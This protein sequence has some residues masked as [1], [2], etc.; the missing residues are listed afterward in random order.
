MTPESEILTGKALTIVFTVLPPVPYPGRLTPTVFT[1][2]TGAYE[3]SKGRRK[4]LEFNQTQK[5]L[6]ARHHSPSMATGTPPR[7]APRPRVL[8][9]P[10]LGPLPRPEAIRGGIVVKDAS[11]K[12]RGLA[13]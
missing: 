12:W 5:Y 6:H 10:P 13:M 11:Q 7:A 2:F 4:R 8:G 3:D 1:V 9:P